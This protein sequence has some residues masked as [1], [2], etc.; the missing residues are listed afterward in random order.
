MKWSK[1]T[2]N[3]LKEFKK[4]K[5]ELSN[6][7]NLVRIFRAERDLII[8]FIKINPKFYVKYELLKNNQIISLNKKLYEFAGTTWVDTNSVINE[9]NILDSGYL[10]QWNS[11]G[12]FDND[13][14]INYIYVKSDKQMKKSL[15]N[16]IKL[17][18]YIIE[19]LKHKNNQINKSINM[20][21]VLT[22]LQKKF[23]E[24]NQIM[25]IK[26]ANTGYTD[27][28]KNIIYIWRKEEL[29]KVIFHE[30]CHY[31]DM[32]KRDHTVEHIIN[33]NGP[34]SYYEA[35]TDFW[36][37]L[38]NLVFVSILSKT[39]IKLLLNIELGFIKNQAMYLN[40][41][42]KIKNWKIKSKD[43]INQI[44]PAFSYYILKFMIFEYLINNNLDYNYNDLIS[45]ISKIGF[46]QEPYIKLKSSRMT[47]IQLE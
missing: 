3:N 23:P 33:I 40:E 19:Y 27:F 41:Y 36:G 46:I 43:I 22:N 13:S 18:A 1:F 9:I 26:N 37:I 31:L 20:F 5:Y 2:I 7:S 45:N 21:L 24:N 39:S 14:T 47:I 30:I 8:N 34:Y 16:K 42:L 17:I 10:Y 6:N 35:I 11:I 25:G 28:R 4:N 29:E 44:S 12:D 32:D 15:N 38:Y